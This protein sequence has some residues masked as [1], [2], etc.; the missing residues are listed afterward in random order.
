M[1]NSDPPQNIYIDTSALRGMNFKKEVASLLAFSKTGKIRLYISETTLWE[2]GRQQHEMD[3]AGDRVVPILRDALNRYIAWFKDIFIEYGVNILESNESIIKQVALHI[4]SDSSYFKQGN[5][6]DLRD[7]HVLATAELN[8]EKN[9]LILCGDKKLAQSFKDIAGF[10]NVREDCKEFLL[11]MVGEETNVPTLDRPSLDMLDEYRISTTFS[12]SF[13]GFINKADYRFY[14]YLKTLPSITD[15]LNAK[16]NNMTL[17]DA[18]IRKRVLGYTQWFSPI[19]KENLCQLLEPR[20]YG[21]MEIENNAQRLKQENLLIETEN[22]WLTNTQKAEEKE[23]CEQAM[24]VV[25]PEIL[26]IMELS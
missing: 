2:R 22:H 18:E 24:A 12:P 16:L 5:E 17:L 21:K 15:K 8:L 3:C 11:E 26:E 6:N 14:E 13:L 23:I 10:P 9:T 20:R 19:G 1:N 25:M 7:A 4:Q